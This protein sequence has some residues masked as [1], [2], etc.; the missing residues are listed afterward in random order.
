MSAANVW[1]MV[2]DLLLLKRGRGVFLCPRFEN[3]RLV[4]YTRTRIE[5]CQLNKHFNI[6]L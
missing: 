1:I 3:R 2:Y 5:E 6:Y 4:D